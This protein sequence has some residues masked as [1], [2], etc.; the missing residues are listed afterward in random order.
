MPLG[1]RILPELGV[2]A[3]RYV[4]L[5]RLDET[6]VQLQACATH[7]DFHPAFRHVVD[8]RALT[9]FERD[10]LGFFKM[11]A[12]AIDTFPENTQGEH[13]FHMVMLAPSGPAWEMA[14]QVRR[15]WEGLGLTIVRIVDTPEAV[16]DLLGL[17]TNESALLFETI[18]K[19]P[20]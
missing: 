17:R 15:T 8:L 12:A 13:P 1:F 14:D 20:Q 10:V 19:L 6:I 5:A 11:Q 16:V 2:I 3:V 4:G 9:D 7:P 18:A